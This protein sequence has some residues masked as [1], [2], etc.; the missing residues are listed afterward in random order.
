MF[1]APAL[2]RMREK[3]EAAPEPFW[4]LA[5]GAAWLGV[6]A[7][8]LVLCG[9]GFVH[10]EIYSFLPHYLSG[11][12]FFEIITDNRVT[13]WGHYQARDLSF[14]FDYADCQFIDWCWRHGHPHFFS[15]MHY[16]LLLAAGLVL[17]R[18]ATRYCGVRRVL[19]FA[20][21]LLL[22]SGPSVMLYTAFYRVAK[23]GLLLATLLAAWAWFRAR[24]PRASGAWVARGWRSSA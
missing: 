21:V 15:A 6:V 8:S 24:A 10:P 12:P 3:L 2:L 16:L 14:V 22:W 19:A 9:S 1:A 11:Q 18:I 20:L 5:L 17:W 23:M 7:V 13:D 4:L